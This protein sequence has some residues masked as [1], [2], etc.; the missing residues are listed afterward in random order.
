M[1]RLL[2]GARRA[3]GAS[4]DSPRVVAGIAVAGIAAGGAAWLAGAPALATLAW[5]LVTAFALVPLTV[6][7]ARDLLRREPGV[8]LIALLAMTAALALA[9]GLALEAYADTRAR[10]ELSALL[11]RAP[12]TVHRHRR[13]GLETVPVEQ[14]RRGDLLLVGPGEVVPVDGLAGAPAVLDE[15][16]LT[17]ESRP[18]ERPAGTP[19]RSGAVNAG[20]GSRPRASR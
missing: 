9:G 18:V 11:A 2:A 6:A 10:H 15:S 14:V 17:G 7:V 1:T 4:A 13:A 16:A 8:D 3:Y 12:R 5:A 19:V 20:G